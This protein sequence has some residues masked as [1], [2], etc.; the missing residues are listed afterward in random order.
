MRVDVCHTAGMFCNL[1]ALVSFDCFQTLNDDALMILGRDHSSSDSL[2]YV[3]VWSY[4]FA[5]HNPLTA[6]FYIK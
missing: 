4:H 3:E 6:S 2:R 5:V 1:H